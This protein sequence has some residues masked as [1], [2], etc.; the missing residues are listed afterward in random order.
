M[1]LDADKEGFCLRALDAK[2]GDDWDE[3]AFE[4]QNAADV[5]FI[6]V[7]LLVAVPLAR[8]RATASCDHSPNC[9]LSVDPKD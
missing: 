8:A 9:P 7:P 1:V 4:L 2:E 6:D 3:E 5:P